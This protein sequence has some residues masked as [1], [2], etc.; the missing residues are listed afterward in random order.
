ME[1]F[2]KY[3]LSVTR[4]KGYVEDKVFNTDETDLFYNDVG[5]WTHIIKINS[6]APGLKSFKTVQLI[7]SIYKMSLGRN[8]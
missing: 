4:G 3:L 2:F 8:T 6:K 7:I 5:K 1:E